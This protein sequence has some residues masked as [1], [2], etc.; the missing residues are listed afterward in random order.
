[1]IEEYGMVTYSYSNNSYEVPV[2]KEEE[3]RPKSILSLLEALKRFKVKESSTSFSNL[4]IWFQTSQQEEEQH[5]C[6]CLERC[7][8]ER[9]QNRRCNTR[10]SGWNLPRIN[11]SEIAVWNL[12]RFGAPT[13][14]PGEKGGL[15]LEHEKQRIMGLGTS[16]ASHGVRPSGEWHG[17][18]RRSHH[19]VDPDAIQGEIVFKFGYDPK[20]KIHWDEATWWRFAASSKYLLWDGKMRRILNAS[21]LTSKSYATCKFCKHFRNTGTV[22]ENMSLRNGMFNVRMLELVKL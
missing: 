3:P 11:L 1:M 2:G 19:Q 10:N 18:F 22:E 20:S 9:T 4:T 12:A 5:W 15:G 17:V 21:K 8:H 16:G 13:T 14:K 6:R 7:R